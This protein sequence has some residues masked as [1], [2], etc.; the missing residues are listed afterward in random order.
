MRL[1]CVAK[2]IADMIETSDRLV[3]FVVA[4]VEDE[5]DEEGYR[6]EDVE[7]WGRCS[8]HRR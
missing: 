5:P 3:H 6:A 4:G 7:A 1:D 2:G 8:W